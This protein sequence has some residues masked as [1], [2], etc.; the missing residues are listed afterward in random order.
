MCWSRTNNIVDK[1]GAK[2]L[3]AGV[4]EVAFE[5]VC[6]SYGPDE[7]DALK[8]I[9]LTAAPGETLALVG[10]SG[11]GKTSLV[12]LIPRLYDVTGG[13]LTI[14]GTDVRDLTV[15][16]LRDHIFHCDPGA[17]PV[18]RNRAGQYPVR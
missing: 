4:C 10:M 6:F 15:A 18:Q 14:A 8:N 16:S 1:P 7:P 17:H 3:D 13:R 11:G 12:N 5:N 2:N 9:N